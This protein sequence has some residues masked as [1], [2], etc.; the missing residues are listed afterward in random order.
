LKVFEELRKN[1]ALNLEKIIEMEEIAL[2]T[3]ANSAKEKLKL[4]N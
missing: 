4:L 2:I 3:N 1:M